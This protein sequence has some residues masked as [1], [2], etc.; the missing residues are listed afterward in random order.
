MGRVVRF[1][2]HKPRAFPIKLVVPDFG[3]HRPI[4][5]IRRSPFPYFH[6]CLCWLLLCQPR[7]PSTLA[8]RVVPFLRFLCCHRGA[9]KDCAYLDWSTPIPGLCGCVAWFFF[10]M[11]V[12]EGSEM[13]RLADGWR[14]TFLVGGAG[15][16]FAR[17]F[18]LVDFRGCDLLSG[19]RSHVQRWYITWGGVLPNADV[20]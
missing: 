17:S 15:C 14:Q 2:F 11:C 18:E 3:V 20:H 12:S 13:Q 6:S 7:L 1:L 16:D 10:G 19:M 4:A 9:L 8:K 5:F